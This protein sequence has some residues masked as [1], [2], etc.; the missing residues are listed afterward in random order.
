MKAQVLHGINDIRYEDID[1]PR[2]EKGWVLVKIK[3]AGVCGSDIPR[4]YKT[5]AHVHPIVIGH[6]FSGEVIETA[7]DN[8]LLRGKRVGI[9]PLI[10]CR[11]CPSCK[12][13]MYEMCSNYNYLGSRC[14]GGF[15]EYAAVPEWNLIELP[16]NVSY[17]QAAM[18]EPMAVAVHAMRRFNIEKDASVCVIG[19]GTIG[20]LLTMFLKA[21]G[22]QNVYAE[23]NK[24][25]QKHFAQEL[26]IDGKHYNADNVQ[27]DYVF[28]CVGRNE[29]VNRA[30]ELAAPAGHVVFIGNPYSDMNIPKDTYWMILRKQLKL[31]GTWNSSYTGESDDDWHYVLNKL[32]DEQINPE[33]FITHEYPLD[34][35]Q[36]GMKIMC[37]KSE[38]Y[39][40]VMCVNKEEC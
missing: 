34:T 36:V 2:I 40:K 24:D 32:A 19:L 25:M 22:I 9:F 17:K 10:P 11:E 3:A 18:M 37:D 39:V 31:S 5:G 33:K 1:E 28:E 27:A 38:D 4:I 23:G 21:E 20:L 8:S 26:G 15:A 7:D 6:E 16:D 35:I 29:T 30:I 13:K 14:N 12:K